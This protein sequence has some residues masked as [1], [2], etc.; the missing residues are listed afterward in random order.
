MGRL[1]ASNKGVATE[2][3]ALVL[4]ED[5][6]RVESL[7]GSGSA[8]ESSGLGYSNLRARAKR[9]RSTLGSGFRPGFD[10]GDAVPL[11]L[12]KASFTKRKAGETLRPS[13]I[14]SFT[15]E[16]VT[17]F[18]VSSKRLLV[19]ADCKGVSSS[20]RLLT[21]SARN[22]CSCS[23]A[24]GRCPAGYLGSGGIAGKGVVINDDATTGYR[25]LEASC[26]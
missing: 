5:V 24:S 1:V 10:G 4:R 3:P 12:H 26:E 17:T 8:C 22:L 18:W 6:A 20:E 2:G 7:D 16:A 21:A 9:S 23:V 19:K 13:N 11:Y 15:V 14:S 25:N